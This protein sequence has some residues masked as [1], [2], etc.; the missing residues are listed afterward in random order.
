M[1]LVNPHVRLE[2]IGANR[3]RLFP[4]HTKG[5]GLLHLNCTI[6]DA[7]VKLQPFRSFH[8]SLTSL[9]EASKA[10]LE[11]ATEKRCS[12]LYS[13][14][15]VSNSVNVNAGISEFFD[16]QRREEIEA[17]KRRRDEE[18]KVEHLGWRPSFCFRCWS[19]RCKC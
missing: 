4:N 15:Y 9:L 8:S 6:E 12:P 16:R 2:N 5:H 18:W 1:C 19:G 13:L 7:T 11:V 3:D 17:K 10:K 14:P